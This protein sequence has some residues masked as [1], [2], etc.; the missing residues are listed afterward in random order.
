MGD[1]RLVPE[2]LPEEVIECPRRYLQVRVYENGRVE[3]LSDGWDSERCRR[4]TG[5]LLHV[6]LPGGPYGSLRLSPP[7]YR[8]EECL[9]QKGVATALYR[10]RLGG[11][12]P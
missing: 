4:K 10:A 1:L 2:H 12:V 6:G 9:V 11:M 8:D 7:M 5:V 3:V